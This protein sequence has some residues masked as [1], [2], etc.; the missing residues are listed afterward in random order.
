[1]SLPFSQRI[2][3]ALGLVL[4]GS[5]APWNK[6]PVVGGGN[7]VTMGKPYTE[8]GWV[9]AAIRHIARPISSVDLE[10][11]AEAMDGT[12]SPIDDR[13]LSI[14]WKSP[15]VGCSFA[16]FVLATVGWRKLC[17]EAFWLLDDS[18][19][20]PF[21]E[22]R[23][24]FPRLILARPDRMRHVVSG[25]EISGWE[26]RDGDG[27]R[28][29]LLPK[30]VI[31]LR[32]WN[33]YDDYRGA[34]EWEVAKLAAQA[35]F[36]AS[37]FARNLAA[38]NGD[39]G[40]FV[41]GKSGV[42]D[43]AQRK[44]ITAVLAEK[45]RQQQLGNF[46]PAFL[47]G[48]I[49][50]ED[51][52]VR[53][54]DTAFMDGRRMSAAEIFV[55]FGVPPSMAKEQASYSIGSASDYLRLIIDTCKPEAC[56]I[57]SAISV[58]SSIYTGRA[59]EAEFCWD[60]HPVFQQVRT[61]RMASLDALFNKGVPMS[62]AS[63]YLDLGLPRFPGDDIGYLPISITPA[64]DASLAIN[65]GPEGDSPAPAAPAPAA[66]GDPVEAAIHCL[67]HQISNR[68]S[69][70]AREWQAHMRRRQGTIKA[71]RSAFTRVLMVARA[72][73]LRK[74]DH[75]ANAGRQEPAGAVLA[76]ETAENTANA[77][78][79]HAERGGGHDLGGLL[80]RAGAADLMFDKHA[81]QQGLAVA[82]RKVGTEALNT[83]GKQLYAE[84][85]KDDPF[86]YPAPKALQFLR[87]RENKL[88]G[89]SDEVFDSVRSALEEGLDAGESI[90]ELADRIRG[91][92]NDASKER[93]TRIAMTETAAAYGSG[94]QEGMM[95]AGVT[96]KRWLNSGGDNVRPAHLEASNQTVPV[97][98]PFDIG[99]EQLMFPG[100]PSGSPGNVINCHCVS[101]AVATPD[102]GLE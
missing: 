1:M 68:G 10:F 25:S 5:I 28:H 62:V 87:E 38:S 92:F 81:F 16:S 55:I 99:G 83:A 79:P 18:A 64:A 40:P 26:Y 48:D 100:D 84:L 98:E 23:T 95:Q 22:A 63:E 67:K 57:A 93:A 31:H 12:E 80:S 71:Y 13:R 96:W 39:Q 8:S 17:G 51:P 11:Y 78:Q 6:V 102:E 65:P 101:I 52:K 82:F 44:Q 54:I 20:V 47:T 85:G 24:A 46:V 43:E 19:L 89:V 30:Q 72:E 50:V 86:T 94:R 73:V 88:S 49:T 74:L 7:D 36:A 75:K 97:D 77:S 45:R 29:Y 32:Q 56:E 27:R 2:K 35:D 59:I 66:P 37:R 15:A 42:V 53:T 41:I 90:D 61:E 9:Y 33:P 4:K 76:T 34:G 69:K 21:P 60:E 14:F 91:T 3:A 70:Q 58:V